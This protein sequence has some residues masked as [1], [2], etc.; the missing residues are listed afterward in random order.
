MAEVTKQLG[1]DIVDGDTHK[2]V[3]EVVKQLVGIMEEATSIVG[4]F[5]KWDSQKAVKKKI[6]RIILEESFG[7]KELISAITDRFMELAK[8]KFK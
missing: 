2:R 3:I 7:S 1:E 8:V 6:K 4:F 5:D